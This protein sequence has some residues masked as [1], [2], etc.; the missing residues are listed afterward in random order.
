ML[1]VI[2]EIVRYVEYLT[3]YYNLHDVSLDH[4]KN[5]KLSLCLIK[6]YVILSNG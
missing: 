1:C 5:V 3:K 2:S 6:H 4:C